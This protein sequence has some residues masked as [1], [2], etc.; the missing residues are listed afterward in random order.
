MGLVA[1]SAAARRV[2][3]RGTREAHGSGGGEAPGDKSR[4]DAPW[5]IF[6]FVR[7]LSRALAA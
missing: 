1:G 3:A 2:V 7:A 5:T 4:F 6:L